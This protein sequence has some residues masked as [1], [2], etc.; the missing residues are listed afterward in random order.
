MKSNPVSDMNS[1]YSGKWRCEDYDVN[2]VLIDIDFSRKSPIL[3][4]DNDDGEVFTIQDLSFSRNSLRFKTICPSTGIV[5]RYCLYCQN[6][7]TMQ[8]KFQLDELWR[9]VSKGTFPAA[10]SSVNGVWV[11]DDSEEWSTVRLTI[12][13]AR[14]K[15][16]AY[17]GWDKSFLPVYN[18]KFFKHSVHFNCG[19]NGFVDTNHRFSYTKN[20]RAMHSIIW[21]CKYYLY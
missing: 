13:S 17:S 5:N 20:D 1:C 18:E 9:R 7:G 12:D 19:T 21:H 8:V 14:K 2:P 11:Y 15:I 3:A 4:Y 6:Y 10:N 16:I